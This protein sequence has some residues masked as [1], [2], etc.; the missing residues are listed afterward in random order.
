[1]TPIPAERL[2]A[3]LTRHDIVTAT[4]SAGS[5]D[6]DTFVQ[7]SRELSEL[8]G[9][10]AAIHAYRAAAQNLADIEAL[11]DEPG[12]DSEMRALAADEKPE[13]EAGLEA[14]HRALQLI[15]LPKD[16]ADEKSA[17]LEIRA[18]TGGD[19]AALFAGDLFRMYGRYADAKGWKV[20]VISESEGTVGGYREVIAEV[21]GK[22]VFARLKFESGAHRVQR[23]P[24]TETQGRIHTSAATVA[25]L[26]EAE[27]VD[28]VINDADLKIDTMRSQGAGGQ[29]VNKTESAIRITHM[30][31][32]IVIFVQEERSQHKNRARA[33]SLL[34][35]K[36]YD[37]E[38]TAKDAARAADRK[39]QVGSGDRSERIRTYNFPQAR[40]TD[41]R[42]NL[43]LYKLEEVLAGVALDELVDALVTEHQ[44]ELLA[45]EG[46][47]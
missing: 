33:M 10:V 19:E 27:E 47:A 31:S 32:G 7:L 2:D 42:I 18:G 44:A 20:E 38:R 28:I 3:I 6:S 15:L 37:A 46:M 14:A 40:V 1:M 8:E 21:K 22:G 39:S 13:A 25:V 24:D 5:A 36:L 9:V 11:I 17:I 35:S 16:S 29:H 4:L 12:S 45:A 34:R 41:H 43:T 23:V 26:P 30:P